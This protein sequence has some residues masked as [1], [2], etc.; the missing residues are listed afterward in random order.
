MLL[1]PQQLSQ[2]CPPPRGF[3]SAPPPS[4]LQW[5]RAAQES[6]AFAKRP[7]PRGRRRAGI[8]YERKAQEYLHDRFGLRYIPSPWLLFQGKVSD[9]LRWCQ[10]DG[11]LINLPRGH[12]T[13][14]EIKY[15]HTPDA[16]WQLTHLYLPILQKLFPLWTLSRCEVVKW[17]DPAQAFPQ[18]VIL[19]HALEGLSPEEFGV[20]IWKP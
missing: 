8:L 2:P 20:H 14:L 11:L 10:P 9:P 12:I 17:Y 15:Q 7:L 19:T 5:A 1:P 6:P 3:R 4:D 16:W 13:V 18:R